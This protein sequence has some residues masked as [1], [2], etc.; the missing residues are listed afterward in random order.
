MRKILCI[1]FIFAFAVS[2][3]SCNGEREGYKTYTEGNVTMSMPDTLEKRK[4]PDADVY[5]KNSEMSVLMKAFSNQVIKE[6]LEL[7]ENITVTD[8]VI[9]FQGWNGYSEPYYYDSERNSVSFEAVTD[10]KNEF[11]SNSTYEYY[12]FFRR[13]GGIYAL[14]FSCDAS[15]K[16][17]YREVFKYI[18]ST[19]KVD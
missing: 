2:L 1:I 15:L 18:D 4:M 17:S 13:A 16:D 6:E 9:L 14:C 5:Y 3:F 7:Y 19:V 10:F 12:L 11:S 8:Y